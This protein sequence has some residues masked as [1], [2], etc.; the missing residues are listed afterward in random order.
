M[1]K[2]S[3]V[4]DPIQL[5]RDIQGTK[6]VYKSPIEPFT[7]TIAHGMVRGRPGLRDLRHR[8]H[9]LH[10]FGLKIGSLVR[11]YPLKQP[12]VAHKVV[13]EGI[14]GRLRRHVPSRNRLCESREMVC[15]NQDVLNTTL[16]NI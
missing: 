16:S 4:S 1:D 15:D 7:H 2:W 3:Y 9:F 12:V 14:S 5:L 10:Q 8:A 6:H 13:D 11:M